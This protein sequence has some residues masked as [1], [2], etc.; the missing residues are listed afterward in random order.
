MLKRCA[1]I[2]FVETV[3]AT[4]GLRR[5]HLVLQA[6]LCFGGVNNATVLAFTDKINI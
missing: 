3:L 6:I 2:D 5:P 1:S 4:M